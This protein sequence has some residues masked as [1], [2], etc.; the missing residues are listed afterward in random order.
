M[1]VLNTQIYTHCQRS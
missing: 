1:I